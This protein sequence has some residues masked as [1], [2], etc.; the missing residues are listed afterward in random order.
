[1]IGNRELIDHDTWT[2]TANSQTR[3]VE[4]HH[5]NQLILD[6]GHTGKQVFLP[7]GNASNNYGRLVI[8]NISG[9]NVTIKDDM[10][11]TD[12]TS[13]IITGHD[14]TLANNESVVCEY[15]PYLKNWGPNHKPKTV[16]G[17]ERGMWLVLQG[18][19]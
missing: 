7:S 5:S 9:Q 15:I 17:N 11:S 14:H 6:G 13:N 2:S 19:A 4:W 16:H 3:K 10:T 12:T 8:T 18:K 1:M